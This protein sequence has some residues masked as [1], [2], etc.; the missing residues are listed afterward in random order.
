[1]IASIPEFKQPHCYLI[2]LLKSYLFQQD[3]NRIS[4]DVNRHYQMLWLIDARGNL[5][6]FLLKRLPHSSCSLASASDRF[7][8]LCIR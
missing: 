1:M 7:M 4:Y 3:I 6:P 8:L 2:S 5:R